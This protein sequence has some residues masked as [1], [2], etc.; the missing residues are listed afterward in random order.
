MAHELEIK[1]ALP[2]RLAAQLRRL[3]LLAGVAGQKRGMGDLYLDTPEQALRHRRMALRRRTAGGENYLTLKTEGENANGFSRR[4][5]W[6]YPLL[7]DALDFSPIDDAQIRRFLQRAASRLFPVFR[8]DFVRQTWGL[9]YGDSRVELALDLGHIRAGGWRARISEVELELLAG[10]EADLF[11]L[12][13]TLMETL[14]L[15]PFSFSKAARGYALLDAGV[16]RAAHGVESGL[17]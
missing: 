10:R 1:L 14:P 5:E 8:T 11:R 2:V 4:Q 6:E 9:P 16:N 12:A 7:S 13:E 15:R 3:P 17:S